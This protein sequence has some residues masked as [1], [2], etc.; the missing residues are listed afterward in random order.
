LLAFVYQGRSLVLRPGL[1][2]ETP[3][4]TLSKGLRCEKLQSMDKDRRGELTVIGQEKPRSVKPLCVTS[5]LEPKKMRFLGMICPLV[6]GSYLTYLLTR[7]IGQCSIV[8]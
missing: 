3:L 5:C 6:S 1:K 4:Y 2:T 8:I 7:I